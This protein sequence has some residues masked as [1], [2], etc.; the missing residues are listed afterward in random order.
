MGMQMSLPLS[1]FRLTSSPTPWL[2]PS[3]KSS[4]SI[5][6]KGYSTR[7][8]TLGTLSLH[9]VIWESEKLNSPFVHFA[10]NG[11]ILLTNLFRIGLTNEMSN[12]CMQSNTL[13]LISKWMPIMLYLELEDV[14]SVAGVLC[15]LGWTCDDA[16]ALVCLFCLVKGLNSSHKSL[17][18]PR[19]A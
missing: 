3:W 14:A 11:C 2:R 8:P 13:F 15:S 9:R 12:A 17:A 5:V 7:S 10:Q 19:L 1:M 16:L 18:L 6:L 4:V